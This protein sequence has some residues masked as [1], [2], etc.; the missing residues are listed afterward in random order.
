M[1]LFCLGLHLWSDCTTVYWCMEW[2]S[3]SS[4]ACFVYVVILIQYNGVHFNVFKFIL[5]CPSAVQRNKLRLSYEGAQLYWFFGGGPCR[6][7]RVL[8]AKHS[9]RNSPTRA[10]RSKWE[11][12]GLRGVLLI[13]F[14]S[15]AVET[16]IV[17]KKKTHQ[18]TQNVSGD[19]AFR[20]NVAGEMVPRRNI[21]WEL[22]L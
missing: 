9:T 7:S 10:P 13:Y 4:C 18:E 2:L 15:R 12:I 8:C 3:C 21:G 22:F 6:K 1:I 19:V 14:T 17:W 11:R 5:W 16:L 20:R